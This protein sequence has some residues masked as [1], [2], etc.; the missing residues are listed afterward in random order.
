MP[1]LDDPRIAAALAPLPADA[2][3]AAA[4][5][6][7]PQ[8]E[9]LE[10]EI[11]KLERLG[12]AEVHWPDIVREAQAVLATRSKDLAV[13]A[14]LTVALGQ[15]EGLAG[16]TTGLAIVRDLV[17]G[18]WERV[19]PQRPRARAGVFQ[20]LTARAARLVPA[21]TSGDSAAA[22]ALAAFEEIDAL[23]R[24]LAEKLPDPGV[25]LGE[26]LRPLR[27]LAQTARRA[28]A[29]RAAQAEAAQKAAAAP[30]AP[31]PAPAAASP[32]RAAVPAALTVSVPQF[33]DG[34]TEKLFAALRE[35]V[36]TAALQ[37]L[38]ADPGEVR[39]YQLLRAVTWL[40]L[41]EL[42]PARGGRTELMPPPETRRTEF[43]ALAKAGNARDLVLAIES[44]CSGSGFFWLDGQR[45]SATTLAGMGPRFAACSQAVVQ[46]VQ[47]LLRRLPG[48]QELAFSDGTPFADAPTRAW[49]DNI[50]MATTTEK[51][52]AGGAA[53]WETGLAAA[54][55]KAGDG[56]AEAALAMLADGVAGA[57]GGRARFLWQLAAATFCLE[58]GAAAV[59]VPVLQHLDRQI[60][61]HGLE[62]WEPEVAAQAAL[63]LHRS[64]QAP[65][66]AVL[67]VDGERS[68]LADAAF[69]RLARVDP[70]TAARV[71]GTRRG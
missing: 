21:E 8:F 33:S 43:E 39:A 60:D 22:V 24:L 50:V 25:A 55:Q 70:V 5:R 23:D 64:L 9:A 67:L 52:S 41:T 71:A 14:W 31:A 32:A 12:P 26:L 10:S 2:P 28:A 45:L 11:G 54:R 34:N 57:P 42:P 29:E 62:E 51:G 13:A 48:L 46:G 61:R 49:I 35:A 63:M 40:P 44:F 38:E 19:F 1:R 30:P 68:A 3:D 66:G 53:P 27:T 69:A 6:Y 37:V 56:E 47:A 20:W 59:A 4:F 58:S 17:D 16:L 65:N 18:Q 7:D 36:R 15:T